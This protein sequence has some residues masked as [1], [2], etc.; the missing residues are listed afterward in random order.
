ML[1][2]SHVFGLLAAALAV[3]PA[4]AFA[5]QVQGSSSNTTQTSVTSIFQHQNCPTTN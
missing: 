3:S 5:D 2:K 4:A 1:K